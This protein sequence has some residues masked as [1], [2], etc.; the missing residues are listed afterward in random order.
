[1]LGLN[2]RELATSLATR[3]GVLS[4]LERFATRPMLLVLVYHRVM[5]IDDCEYDTDVIEATPDQFH[6]QMVMLRK[7]HSIADPDELIDLAQNPSKIRHFRVAITFDDGYRDNY[8][9]AFPILKG[10]G[11]RAAFF[12]PTHFVGTT[13]LPWWDR[14]AHAIRN[15][16]KTAIQLRRPDK[17]TTIE[18]DPKNPIL[19]VRK[20]LKVYKKETDVAGFLDSVEEACGRALPTNATDRQFM[21]W[22]EAKE[23]QDGGMSMGSHTHSHNILGDL[24]REVQEK[25][26]ALS[27]DLLKGHGL[28]PKL[29]AYPVGN[30]Q[31]FSKTTIDCAKKAGY[32]CAFSNYGGLNLPDDLNL[33][34]IKRFG[35]STEQSASRLRMRLALANTRPSLA[36]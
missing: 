35:M 19:A 21:S 23:M 20:V 26:C 12:L 3:L 16:G 10:Q 30:P 15:C 8:D 32:A 36:G 1:M 11:I 13:H 14:I 28:D 6:E 5:R 4:L 33:F 2:R 18:I 7:R 22:T 9:N 34:D 24:P 25:E 27:R 17:T 29:F 31:A